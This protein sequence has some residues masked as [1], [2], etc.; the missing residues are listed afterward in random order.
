[1]EINIIRLQR[2]PG[3]NNLW[4]GTWDLF[5]MSQYKMFSL[6]LMVNKIGKC[7]SSVVHHA[8]AA[9]LLTIIG[10]FV[11]VLMKFR[12]NPSEIL[13]KIKFEFYN[14]THKIHF[15]YVPNSNPGSYNA[16]NTITNTPRTHRNMFTRCWI[17]GIELSFHGISPLVSC[18]RSFYSIIINLYMSMAVFPSL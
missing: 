7:H 13:I 14:R 8:D 5:L 1:M 4:T 6:C 12:R 16:V 11:K 3:T 10:Y 15:N 2:F 18:F 9:V 17:V